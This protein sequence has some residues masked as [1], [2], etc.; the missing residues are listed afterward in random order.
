MEI[1]DTTPAALLIVNHWLE[2]LATG[3]PDKVVAMYDAKSCVLVPTL[4][5]DPLR[6]QEAIRGYFVDFIANHPGLHGTVHEEINQNLGEGR[7]SISGHYTFFWD[8]GGVQD[9][10]FTFVVVETDGVWDIHTHHSS[11]NPVE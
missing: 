4:G 8:G 6:G 2:A 1:G 3:D 9:A 11:A 10:R 7:R 5:N